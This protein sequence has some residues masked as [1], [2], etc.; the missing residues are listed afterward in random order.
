[1]TKAFFTCILLLASFFTI[2]QP[3]PNEDFAQFAKKQSD[4]FVDA[5]NKKDVSLYNTLLKE[6]L[7]KYEAL[8]QEEQKDFSPYYINAYYNLSCTYSLLN[9]K[10]MALASL[11]KAIKAGYA[12]YG[13]LS[14]DSDLDNIRN[15][16][17]YEAMVQPLRELG[18]YLYML[19]RDNR[20][21][22]TDSIRLPASH[23]SRTDASAPTVQTRLHSRC[24]Q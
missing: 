7:K 11:E 8:K 4:L 15:E 19:R 2:A 1:M 10:P 20:F 17:A 3:S 13:H 14:K 21:T 18:D 5:Y 12:N 6:F 23:A 16:K 22:T 24:R 9:N